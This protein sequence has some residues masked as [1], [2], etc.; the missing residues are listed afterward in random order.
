MSDARRALP[1]VDAA[2]REPAIARL[3]GDHPRARVVDA[4]REAL[5]ERRAR[6]AGGDGL[7]EQVAASLRP[8]LRPVLN[9]T[10]VILH[11]NLGRAPLAPEAVEAVVRASAY[12][13][14][15]WRPDTGE[16]GSRH[17]HVVAHLRALTGAE[18]ACVT[19]TNAGAVLLALVALASG[20]DVLIS[21]GQLVEIGGGF[22]VPE[23]IEASGC[24]LVEVGTTN[25]TRLADYERAM[26]PRTGA[27]L[28]VHPSNFR[29]VG[30]SEE[31]AIEELAALARGAGLALIDDLGSG[32]LRPDP[33]WAGEPDARASVAAGCDLVAF[34]ADKLLGGPQAGILAG[35]AEAVGRARAHPLMRALRPDKLILAGLEA[36]LALHR[37][38]EEARR[39]VPALAALHRDPA[40]RRLRAER[41]ARAVSGEV[42]ASVGRMGGG[43][44][45]LAELPSFAVALDGERPDRL[46]GAL[47]AGE[48]AVA[49]RVEGGRVLLDVL[50]LSD[51]DLEALPELVRRAR[52]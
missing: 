43:T 25:R 3:M 30:F 47:R 12:T 5:A 31:P 23:V 8:S 9:A 34:S 15:E 16:R 4:V 46:A 49:A 51:A 52:P 20:R 21:R 48:P 22:R 13:T 2:L 1:S 11:T 45:P 29:V 41:L 44:L 50:A 26:G 10:G 6:R 17:D 28:R 24:R 36:T 32:A 39:A 40:E 38:P 7:A 35:R 33:L 37:D 14:L 18:A 42:V 19:G 27:I